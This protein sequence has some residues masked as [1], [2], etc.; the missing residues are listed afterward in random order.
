VA[1]RGGS[2]RLLSLSAVPNRSRVH[3]EY[4]FEVSADEAPVIAFSPSA[5]PSTVA[6]GWTKR[7]IVLYV[8]WSEGRWKIAEIG[9]P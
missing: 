8:R 9:L 2:I 6:P 1:L 4:A 5:A 7:K 3:A